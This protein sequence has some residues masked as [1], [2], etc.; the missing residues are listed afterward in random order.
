MQ[1]SVA[2]YTVYQ[3]NQ[4]EITK[5]MTFTIVPKRI[6]S[7]R[8]NISRK[9][10]DNENYKRSLKEIEDINK[11]KEIPYSRIGKLNAVKI[12]ILPKM[13]YRFN[14]IPISHKNAN[15]NHD[16]SNTTYPKI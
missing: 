7:L 12:S 13:I 9:L 2:F 3:T 8:I 16:S 5:I 10:K 15:Y 14:V 1:Y 6:N 4:K 11:W